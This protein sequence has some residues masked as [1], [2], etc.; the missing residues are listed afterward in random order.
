MTQRSTKEILR[1]GRLNQLYATPP[2][3]ATK[4]ENIASRSFVVS[5]LSKVPSHKMRQYEHV[6]GHIVEASEFPQK[7][8]VQFQDDIL[9]GDVGVII[10]RTEQSYQPPTFSTMRTL[11]GTTPLSFARAYILF[12]QLSSILMICRRKGAA[13]LEYGG[14]EQGIMMVKERELH[15]TTTITITTSSIVKAFSVLGARVGRC[16]RKALRVPYHEEFK[17]LSCLEVGNGCPGSRIQRTSMLAAS[18]WDYDRYLPSRWRSGCWI[19]GRHDL[20]GGAMIRQHRTNH[21]FTVYM[22]SLRAPKRSS[23]GANTEESLVS[24][25]V[26]IFQN[27]L[28]ASNFLYRT[29]DDNDFD[30]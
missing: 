25:T 28:S 4:E 5:G 9:V 7:L 11:F 21:Q 12:G 30:Y 10:D 24:R 27:L 8:Y 20:T 15:F 16:G 18:V 26:V 3:R 1:I 17:A 14:E 6:A 29:Q 13:A 19:S 22:Q 23:C 2:T